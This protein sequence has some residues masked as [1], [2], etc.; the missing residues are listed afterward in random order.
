MDAMF[1]FFAFRS[2]AEAL[3]R[4]QSRRASRA[5]AKSTMAATDDAKTDA[6]PAHEAG[7][8]DTDAPARVHLDILET[9]KLAQTQHGLRQA[10]GED[11]Q[12]F[13][14]D[15]MR[16]RQYCARRLR[17]IRRG[18]KVTHG[19][20]EFKKRA[21]DTA[22]VLASGDER[23]LELSLMAVERAWAHSMELKEEETEDNLRPG[24]HHRRRLAKVRSRLPVP[25]LPSP[26]PPHAPWSVEYSPRASPPRREIIYQAHS[27]PR[28]Q[29]RGRARAQRLRRHPPANSFFAPDHAADT[30]LF[31]FF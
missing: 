20:R 18:L 16:Y 10:T 13:L 30:P 5:A 23:H 15:Y 12:Q 14:N 17:R 21:V 22:K 1:L 2:A 27:R 4:A 25:R 7:A 9:L 3:R 24:V 8:A 19:R 29:A 28:A 11:R 6:A 26:V 31:V